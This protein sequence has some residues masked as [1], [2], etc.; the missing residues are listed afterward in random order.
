MEE[1]YITLLFLVGIFLALEILLRGFSSL[2]L[3][4]EL[5]RVLF[6]FLF[7]FSKIYSK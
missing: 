5:N 4:A 3:G 2:H 1:A 7:P 6:R